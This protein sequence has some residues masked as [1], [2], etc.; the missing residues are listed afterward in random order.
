MA[1]GNAVIRFD[2][3]GRQPGQA[4]RRF[5]KCGEEAGP[6]AS[7]CVCSG[8]A[9]PWVLVVTSSREPPLLGA[10]DGQRA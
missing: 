7:V 10:A 3:T 1:A 4:G 9:G 2:F 6:H 8:G 5:L